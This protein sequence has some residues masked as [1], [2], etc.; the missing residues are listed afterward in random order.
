MR[1]AVPA[2]TFRGETRV[3]LVPRSIAQLTGAKAAVAVQTGAGASAGFP[4]AAYREVGAEMVADRDKVLGDADVVVVVRRPD[5][6][7]LRKLREG[8]V[9][10]GLLDPAG[11]PDP[12]R[13]LVERRITAFRMEALPRISRAQDMDVLSSMATLAGYHAAVMAAYRLPRI[14][15]L[16]MTAAG[17]LTPARTLVLGAG[18]AGLQAIATC[19]RLG[20]VVEAYDVRPAVR[21][22]VESLG[23]RFV[24]VGIESAEQQDAGGYAKELSADAQK[25]EHEVLTEHVRDS[26]VVITT[27]FVPGKPA[28]VLVTRDMV[29][30]MRPGSVIVDLAASAGGNCEC[31]QPDKDVVEHGVTILG[32]TNLAAAIPGQASQLYSHNVTRFTLQMLKDGAVALDFDDPV[33]AQ[34]CMTHD[35]KAMGEQMAALVGAPAS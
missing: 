23:A 14:F 11:D 21:E 13:V 17:T 27:A 1:I 12:V 3:A 20:A 2:E 24:E 35:G 18:V 26:D 34:T 5:A 4:D 6:A 7:D 30:A 8:S 33:I 9:L 28:P 16:L 10:I 32:P 19:R 25:R 29:S 31:T 15:P 22:Q